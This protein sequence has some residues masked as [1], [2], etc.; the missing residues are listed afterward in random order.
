MKKGASGLVA[1]VM[2]PITYWCPYFES[3]PTTVSLVVNI[4]P[5]HV[6]TGSGVKQLV[7]SLSLP[8]CCP[9]NASCSLAMAYMDVML[10]T[11]NGMP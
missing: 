2:G 11:S 4:Y 8:T 6:C 3:L 10:N 5:T 7:L 9:R 1:M